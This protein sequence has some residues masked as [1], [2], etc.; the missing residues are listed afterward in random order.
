MGT[1]IAQVLATHTHWPVILVDPQPLALDR[2]RHAIQQSLEKLAKKEPALHPSDILGKIITTPDLADLAPADFVIEAVVENEQ[3]K[4]DLFHQLDA[5]LPDHALLASNTSSISLTRLAAATHR[6]TQVVGMHFMNPPPLMRL[7]EVIRGAQTS[8]ETMAMTL[9]LARQLH[10]TPVESRD[11]PGFIANR[12]LMPMIN[13]AVYA[14]YE[15]VGTVEGIDTVMKLGMNHPMGPL[16]LADFIGLDT[17]LAIL[18][19]LHAG[20]GDPRFRPCPLLRQYVDAGFLGRKAGRG[21]YTYPASTPT[22]GECGS[23]RR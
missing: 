10:K 1:G 12:V 19:V 20:F 8:D 15:G 7:V 18:E 14:V 9:A 21:F 2:S 5:L 6:P 11:Y 13:E 23:V 3:I 17:V 22:E 16:T 4:K